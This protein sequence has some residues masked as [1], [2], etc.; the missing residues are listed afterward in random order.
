[1]GFSE[2]SQ[3]A[4]CHEKYIEELKSSGICGR[5]RWLSSIVVR[6]GSAVEHGE[7]KWED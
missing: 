5:Y 1:M 3:L 6:G 4:D 2:P 7:H